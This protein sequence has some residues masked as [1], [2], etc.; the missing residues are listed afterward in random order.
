MNNPIYI[1]KA[2]QS[3]QSS[4]PG[5]Y[6]KREQLNAIYNFLQLLPYSD[7]SFDTYRQQLILSLPKITHAYEVTGLNP[8]YLE[9]IYQSLKGQ[10]ANYPEMS[11]YLNS[12]NDWV[13]VVKQWVGNDREDSGNQALSVFENAAR[14]ESDT[15]TVLV[16]VVE[17]NGQNPTGRLRNLTVKTI[18]KTPSSKHELTQVFSVR[19]G[20][21]Q[22]EGSKT[23]Q[24][25]VQSLFNELNIAQKQYWQVSASF[26]H[27]DAWHSGNSADLAMAGLFFCAIIEAME[28]KEQFRLN[29]AIA[30]TGSINEHGEVLPVA[31]NTLPQKVEAAFYSWSQILVVPQSQLGAVYQVYESLK[32]RYPNRNFFIVGVSHLR[33]L[34]YDRRLTLHSKK[35]TLEHASKKLWKRKTSAL[36]ILGYLLLATVIAALVIGPVDRNP[37]VVEFIGAQMIIKNK[38]GQE[39]IRKFVGEDYVKSAN[40]SYPFELTFGL[41]ADLNSDGTNEYL[42][43]ERNDNAQ[44]REILYAGNAVGDTLSTLA[45]EKL[46]VYEKHEYIDASKFAF[47]QIEFN[48]FDQNGEEKLVISTNHSRYFPSMILIVD[49]LTGIV[50]S[51]LIHHGHISEFKLLD[52]TNNGKN[53]LIFGGI[54]NADK[55]G[56]LT[57]LSSDQLKGQISVSENYSV[58]EVPLVHPLF[59]VSFPQTLVSRKLAK[60]PNFPT[61]VNS[62]AVIDTG[63]ITVGVQETL[64]N[65]NIGVKRMLS[66]Q[67]NFD[68]QLNVN[69]IAPIDDYDNATMELFRNGEIDFAIP[70]DYL[71]EFKDSLYYWNGTDWVQEPTLNPGYLKSVEEDSS[72]YKEWFFRED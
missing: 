30:I 8:S 62:I 14:I 19:A 20:N 17:T 60:E 22:N 37:E 35:S 55:L 29:P 67:Y 50:E 7:R 38:N 43:K 56:F 12:L 39:L 68:Y 65:Q 44:Y 33:E 41:I 25:A 10:Y 36:A 53:E 3:L 18:G 15:H 24:K 61:Q 34:F 11:E 58:Q 71:S 23:I 57:I 64:N 42:W 69:S 51:E 54:N 31:E 72:Y 70:G 21:H 66:L 9:H 4:L 59:Y 48:S 47:R 45:F 28:L 5:L 32:E 49:P 46:L 6:S 27:N 16:P 1:E 40:S 2:F 52:I 13:D 26:E 63:L